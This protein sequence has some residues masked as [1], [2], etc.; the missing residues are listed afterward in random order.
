MD[1]WKYWYGK[2]VYIILKNKR[3]YQGV[4]LEI[5]SDIKNSGVYFITI[6]DKFDNR[7]SFV[8]S[9]IEL[10]QEEDDK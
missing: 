4:V 1:G 6:K 10:I 7:T 5:E 8:N 2:K 9:E 3:Q